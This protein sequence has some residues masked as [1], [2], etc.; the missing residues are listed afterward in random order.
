MFLILL[1]SCTLTIAHDRDSVKRY[2][3]LVNNA[4]LA[5]IDSS[6]HK[7]NSSYKQAFSLR[8]PSAKDAYNSFRTA[9]LVRDTMQ[10]KFCF[11][12][13][14]SHGLL[15]E[16]LEK[17][18]FMEEVTSDMFYLKYIA[19]D[20]EYYFWQH[21]ISTQ[22]SKACFLDSLYAVDQYYR[23]YPMEEKKID[24]NYD[25]TNI[26]ALVNKVK[27]WKSF[28]SSDKVGICY[29]DNQSISNQGA[30]FLLHWH[31]RFQELSN[32][33]TVIKL[34]SLLKEAVLDGEYDPLLYAI[35]IDQRDN[36]YGTVMTQDML[37]G[38]QDNI[39]EKRNNIYLESIED[40]YSKVRYS[41]CNQSNPFIFVSKWW[42]LVNQ[43]ILINIKEESEQ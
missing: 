26:E 8:F 1:F 28:P 18:P 5:L 29:L 10:A 13:M 33:T 15:R 16:N 30:I 12:Y 31:T 39:N 41:M 42:G 40:T 35:T 32:D 14:I 25:R 3:H 19:W 24:F 37:N 6:Y 4:E 21:A 27:E 7:A 20:D 36:K 11:G 23:K 2:Y 22:K 34:D 38:G 43:S 17:M 9:F